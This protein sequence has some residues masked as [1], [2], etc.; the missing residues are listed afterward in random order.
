[1]K[2]NLWLLGLLVFIFASCDTGS[3]VADT[4]SDITS[5]HQLDGTWVGTTQTKPI[6]LK[7][8]VEASGLL[9][10]PDLLAELL[11]IEDPLLIQMLTPETIALLIKDI[12]VTITVKAT[13]TFVAYDDEAGYM[14]DTTDTTLTFSGGQTKEVWAMLKAMELFPEDLPPGV[15]INDKNHSITRTSDVS[16]TP[17]TLEGFE[18]SQIN[19]TGTKLRTVLD[20]SELEEFD[21]FEGKIPSEIILYKK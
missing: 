18:G 8:I 16:S 20:T 7:D 21:V 14:S 10:D 19:Q 5:L 13:I 3:E 17:I 9:E 12:N 11:G 15:T 6:P 1:M 2:K 4:W